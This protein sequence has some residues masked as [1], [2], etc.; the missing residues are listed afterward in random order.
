MNPKLI[1]TL[2]IITTILAVISFVFFAT[3]S[4]IAF[5]IFAICL[6][7]DVVLLGYLNEKKLL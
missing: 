2:F 4:L 5:W 7:I 1:T 6:M 3:G